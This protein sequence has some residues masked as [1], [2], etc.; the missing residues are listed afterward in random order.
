MKFNCLFFF[1]M[2]QGQ[3]IEKFREIILYFV[4]VEKMNS[5]VVLD[6]GPAKGAARPDNPRV[7]EFGLGAVER[8]IVRDPTWRD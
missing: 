1:E 4:K 3:S 6:K 2:G 7:G 5:K 8:L